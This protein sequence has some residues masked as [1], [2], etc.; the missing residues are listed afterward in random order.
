MNTN[1]INKKERSIIAALILGALFI[2]LPVKG[3]ADL[4]EVKEK[5]EKAAEVQS[6][7][8]KLPLYFI[9]NKGQVDPQVA[10]YLQGQNAAVY[11]TPKGITFTLTGP[12]TSKTELKPVKENV[13]K[14]EPVSLLPSHL[15]KGAKGEPEPMVDRKR[16]AVN[17]DFI[18]A[19]PKATLA[20]ESPLPAV[21]SYFKGSPDQWKTGLP[22]YSRLVYSNLWPGIDLIYAG[23][24]ARLKYEFV[25]HPGADP[26]TIRLAYRGAKTVQLNAGGQLEIATPVGNFG[27]DKPYVYQVIDGKEVEV[28]SSYR[29]ESVERKGGEIESVPYGFNV[30]D[31][32]RT[33]PLVLDPVVFL[34]AG[35]IGGIGEDFGVDIAVDATGAAYVTGDTSSSETT[36]PITVGPD[37]TLTYSISSAFVAK[38]KPDGTGLVYAGYIEG[39][40]GS[41]GRGIAVDATGAAYV[42]GYTFST[43]ATFPVTVG[44]DL[45]HNGGGILPYDAFVAKVNP[46]GTGLDYAGYIGGDERDFSHGIAVD[47]MGAAYITGYT[48]STETT[49]PVTVGPD[50]TFN[51]GLNDAF[52]AK[53]KSDG[54]GLDYAGYIDGEGETD[55]IGYGIAVDSVGSA[56][57][58]G[59][60][61]SPFPVTV[62]PDLTFNGVNDAFVAKVKPDGTGLDY[63]GYIGGDGVDTGYGIAV[64]T[65]GAAYVT[66]DT[67][68]TE[69]TFPVTVGPDLTFN[70]GIGSS[71][72]FVAKV[73]PDGTGLDYAGYIGGEGGTSGFG[74]AV[75]ATSAAYV[76]GYTV[77]T[78]ATFPVTVGPDLTFNGVY[79]AFVAKVKPNGTE[80]D[81]AGYIGGMYE[82]LGLG[83]A[84]D[85]TGA[86]Y[87]TGWTGSAGT[88]PVTV[89]PDLTHNG[90]GLVI[91]YDAFV[92]KVSTSTS[93]QTI[94]VTK[95][96]SGSGTVTSSPAGINCGTDCSEAYPSGTVV[97]L[98]AAPATGSSFT[99]WSGGGCSGTGTCAVTLTADTTVTATFT[100]LPPLD[101]DSDGIPD[102]VDECPLLPT[103]NTITGTA[104]NNIL[105]GTPANDL[106]RGLGGNDTI[107]GQGGNDCLVGGNG[108]DKLYGQNGNDALFGGDGN[109][110]A[111]GGNGQDTL[112]GG[113]GNDRLYGMNGNDTATG[114][115]GTDKLYGGNGNDTLGGNAG[116][117]QLFGQ[118]GNDALNGGTNTDQC[119]GGPGVDTAV[120]CETVSSI[121]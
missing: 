51:G 77:S 36:F 106:I 5:T 48:Y 118:A 19:N 31:Y 45:T 47:A 26:K 74:I 102:T 33:R 14:A 76:T 112:D 65:T 52:V 30:G 49:F 96:G 53:V 13:A 57:I 40:G 60:T 16:W 27:E 82:D 115:D 84:V 111:N 114:G 67:A 28:Q 34:Y 59:M 9:K 72:A 113:G 38:V 21:I 109:D 35:Y 101:T 10:Y 61:T 80:L 98:T 15:A 3:Y 12:E 2:T 71:D 95:T 54:T 85:I 24:G 6:L 79:D 81:Y 110:L 94:T 8:A 87:V 63:A 43:E 100:A 50:V 105:N 86:A 55:S 91:P 64:D 62:G 88:F 107:Y 11:F 56:Y 78:E 1:P 83:I 37:V 116:N 17:L 104:G 73:K 69:A 29:L 120:D 41:F 42:T 121:P 20:A 39:D 7:F 99:G 93:M 92:V 89:G 46:A 68:S 23:A 25:V 117:D 58:T 108:N 90:G 18:G 44:P 103:T 32:D 75:D 119:A 97:T 66:G 70:S 4:V 22:T